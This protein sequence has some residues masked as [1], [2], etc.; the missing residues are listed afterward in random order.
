MRS[1][2]LELPRGYPHKHLK[3]A[4]LPFR[5]DRS[6]RRRG[7]A[8]ERRAFNC[9][10]PPPNGASRTAS[11]PTPTPSPSCRSVS[12]PSA[13]APQMSWS[14]WSSTRRSTPPAPPPSRE[15]LTDPDRFPTFAAGRGG[16]WTYHGPGQR[17]AYVMLDLTRPHGT[18]APARRALLRA[19]P[20]GMADPR[21]RPLRRARRTARRPRRHLGRRAATGTEAKIARHRRSRVAAG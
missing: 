18:R 13:P 7:I 17:M 9:S 1:R 4:R 20:G 10:P 5:H 2:R 12:P 6:G 15:Q 19:R 14:G 21:P 11:P 16:Q 8:D 3:L